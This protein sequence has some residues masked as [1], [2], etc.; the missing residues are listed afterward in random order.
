MVRNIVFDL[1]G[2]LI[3]WNPR[4]LFKNVFSKQDE[5]DFF[6]T[7][8]CS[9]DWNEAQDAG[10]SIA[11]ANAVLIQVYPEYEHQIRMY[12][13]KWT[14]M[15]GG[16]FEEN[17]KLLEDLKKQKKLNLYALTNWSAETFPEACKRYDFLQLFDGIVVSGVEGIKKPDR[18]FFELLFNRYNFEPSQSLFIDDNL[19][20]VQSALKLG[21]PSIHYTRDVD[22]AR[23]LKTRKILLT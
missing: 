3:D 14:E 10:R 12:Y 6:L 11:D 23:E 22:L 19:R 7:E 15:L 13:E 17:I 4:Y 16:V 8:V 5:L 2:V 9:F 20:N 21:M 1:G 18:A